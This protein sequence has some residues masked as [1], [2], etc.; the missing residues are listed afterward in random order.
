MSGYAEKISLPGTPGVVCARFLLNFNAFK[1]GRYWTKFCFEKDQ[2]SDSVTR[3]PK[4]S[5][6]NMCF[7]G[8][9]KDLSVI[10]RH[11]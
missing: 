8:Y 7:T 4:V 5:D 9:E 3:N 2:I 10:R 6:E 1:T 11:D